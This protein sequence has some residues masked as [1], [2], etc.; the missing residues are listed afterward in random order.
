MKNNYLFC[1]AI[2]LL[3]FGSTSCIAQKNWAVPEYTKSLKN[4]FAENAAAT[5]EGKVIYGQMCVLCHGITGEGNGE[6]GLSLEKKPAT[7]SPP[8]PAPII[9]TSYFLVCIFNFN[10]ILQ[11]ALQVRQYH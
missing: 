7:F 4:P 5:A 1:V 10:I 9:I 11:P 2:A 3:F 8:L 6:A